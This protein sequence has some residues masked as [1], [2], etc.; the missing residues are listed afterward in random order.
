MGYGQAKSAM[1]GRSMATMGQRPMV[2]PG[3]D[4]FKVVAAAGR[5]VENE[6]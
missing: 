3:L 1:T 5:I 4:A 2:G 6:G